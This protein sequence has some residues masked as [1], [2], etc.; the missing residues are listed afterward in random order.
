MSADS[1][2]MQLYSSKILALTATIPDFKHL[3][4]PQATVKRRSPLCGSTVLV[5]VNI[6]DGIVSE[7]AQQVRAC[8]LGQ[9]AAAVVG[10]VVIGLTLEQID[11]A[12]DE[13]NNML[14]QGA[15][16]PNPPFEQLHVLQPA[17]DF[18]NRHASIMLSLEAT[19]EAVS[20]A[21]R[22]E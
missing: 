13:L 6:H 12:R 3:E 8:A 7:F 2:L 10:S 5:E 20:I 17:R 22:A 9:A 11:Q 1:D 14:T 19:S 21:S 18:K 16:A 4:N 15:P